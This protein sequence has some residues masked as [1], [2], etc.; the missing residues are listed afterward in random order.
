M[1]DRQNH[2]QDLLPWYVGGSL[3][4]EETRQVDAHLQQC[5]DCAAEIAFLRSVREVTKQGT[6]ATPAEFMWHRLQRDIKRNSKPRG[7]WVPSLAAAAMLVIVVQ[8]VMLFNLQQRPTGYQPAG[9]AAQGIV[10]Q[11]KFNPSVTEQQIRA[12]LAT[13]NAEIVSGPSAAGV[14]RIRLAEEDA[15]I[16][17]QRIDQLKAAPG[18]IDYLE[19]D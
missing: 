11:V 6:E 1:N 18:V 3:S 10:L 9:Q 2:P 14:Y 13:A 17:Q 16:T 4:A 5:A 8:G 12:A 19:R 7:W 15:R